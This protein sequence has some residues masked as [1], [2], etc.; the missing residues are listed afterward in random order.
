[1]QKKDMLTSK[2]LRH[3]EAMISEMTVDELNAKMKRGEIFKLLEVSN[4]NDFEKGHIEGAIHI[5]IDVLETEA[6][7][8]FRK[9]E[10]IVVY[11][12]EASSSVGMVAVRKLQALGF[13]NVLLLRGGSEAW[14][15]A[16]LSLSENKVEVKSEG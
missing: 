11:T 14:Q 9:F 1:M 10:Q 7:K 2:R 13:S 4:P 16:N 8:R 3:L 5:L 15:N 12:R 6:E